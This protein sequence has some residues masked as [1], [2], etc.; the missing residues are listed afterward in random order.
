MWTRCK[1]L[2]RCYHRSFWWDLEKCTQLNYSLTFRDVGWGSNRVYLC[3]TYGGSGTTQFE[4]FWTGL[5]EVLWFFYLESAFKQVSRFLPKPYPLIVNCRFHLIGY[6]VESVPQNNPRNTG[7]L[8]RWTYL[9]IYL[10]I[11]LS[12]YISIYLSVCVSVYLS[13]CL[14]VCLSMAL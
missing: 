9:S 2:G 5:I 4:N 13:I 12:V 14:S 1:N 10:S 7:L 11:Y 8:D 3:A 6:A